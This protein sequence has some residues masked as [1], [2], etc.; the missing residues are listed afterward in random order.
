MIQIT[1]P[2]KA[3]FMLHFGLIYTW[4]YHVF[5]VTCDSSANTCKCTCKTTFREA[6]FPRMFLFLPGSLLKKTSFA[7]PC[8]NTPNTS[9]RVN[10]L[11]QKW[12]R[13]SP[14]SI[15]F[16]VLHH[17]DCL[18]LHRALGSFFTVVHCDDYKS[19]P[20]TEGKTEE[21]LTENSLNYRTQLCG[22]SFC[23]RGPLYEC[24]A[25]FCVLQCRFAHSG[26]SFSSHCQ[27]W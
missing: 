4:C 19:H 6:D 16:T 14:K 21:K 5:C 8:S 20:R 15:N 11:R 1:H 17:T 9:F 10:H 24:A 18:L 25:P 2:H 7:K 27:G 13:C 26:P 3:F 23:P 12:C 22:D